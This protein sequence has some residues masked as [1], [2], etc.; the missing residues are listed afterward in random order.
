MHQRGKDNWSD[1]ALFDARLFRLHQVCRRDRLKEYR[2]KL[3][4]LGLCDLVKSGLA[5]MPLRFD[6]L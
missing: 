1:D 2:V 5:R 3:E 6:P 4:S